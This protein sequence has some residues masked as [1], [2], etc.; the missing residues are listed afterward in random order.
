MSTRKTTSGGGRTLRANEAAEVAASQALSSLGNL[1]IA[2]LIARRVDIEAFGTF[3]VAYSLYVLAIGISRSAG[4]DVFSIQLP[5]LA[6]GQASTAG[7]SSAI[8]AILLSLL[9]VLG[10]VGFT[11]LMVP[12]ATRATLALLFVIPFL[13]WQDTVRM[14]SIALRRP[15]R[16]VWSDGLLLL[17]SVV[18]LSVIPW[19]YVYQSILL[20]GLAAGAAAVAVDGIGILTGARLHAAIAWYVGNRALMS[21]MTGEYLI[22]SGSGQLAV[23][24]LAVTLGLE[25]SG[26]LRAA[27]TMLGPA[28]A[29]LLATS[30]FALPLAAR[31]STG[32]S[33]RLQATI[34]LVA[35]PTLLATLGTLLLVRYVPDPWGL[36]LLGDAWTEAQ[37]VL[38]Y[39]A[40]P[41]VAAAAGLAGRIGLRVT[42]RANI[43]LRINLVV[44]PLGLIGVYFGARNGG[45]SLAILLQAVAMSCGAVAW[46]VAFRR[47]PHQET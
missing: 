23:M 3:G 41:V 26:A 1:A 19:N 24:V 7:G 10:F 39:V 9:A 13:V 2:I 46:W 15:R 44:A 38:P 5:R 20:W 18:L 42:G 12:G 11:A 27:Q 45:L 25:A 21:N 16:A 31:L 36:N 8:T 14:Y 32:A 34:R 22:S 29:V 37:S 40:L 4:T 30:S 33:E 35:V 28:T 43:S 17:F 6:P 47:K